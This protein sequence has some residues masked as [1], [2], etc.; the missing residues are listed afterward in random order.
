MEK[1]LRIHVERL[2]EGVYL[3]TSE[4]FTGDW[5][6]K[7]AQLQK[8]WKSLVMSRVN[9]WKPGLSKTNRRTWS[10][11]PTSLSIP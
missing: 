3:A 6:L 7:G 9:Y 5:W 1:I 10:K 4:R 8:Q 11:L 2:P